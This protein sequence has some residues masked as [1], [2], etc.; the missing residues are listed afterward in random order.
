MDEWEKPSLTLHQ[1]IVMALGLRS[2]VNRLRE[3]YSVHN[4]VMRGDL[5]LVGSRAD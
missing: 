2:L 3:E 4:R 5:H 1:K